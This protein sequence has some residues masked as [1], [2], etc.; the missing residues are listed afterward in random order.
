MLRD[1]ENTPCFSENVFSAG[2]NDGQIGKNMSL[3]ERFDSDKAVYTSMKDLVE[4]IDGDFFESKDKIAYCLS[5]LRAQEVDLFPE[6]ED[7]FAID[8]ATKEWQMIVGFLR[9]K[10]TAL[11]NGTYRCDGELVPSGKI[12]NRSDDLLFEQKFGSYVRK[13]M[14]GVDIIAGTYPRLLKQL[15]LLVLKGDD[16]V[17]HKGVKVLSKGFEF[18]RDKFLPKLEQAL[19]CFL[20]CRSEAIFAQM[21]EVRKSVDKILSKQKNGRSPEIK[22]YWVENYRDFMVQ[23]QLMYAVYD[24]LERILFKLGVIVEA[25]AITEVEIEFDDYQREARDLMSEMAEVV[26]GY[27]KVLMHPGLRDLS[28]EDVVEIK[29]FLN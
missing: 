10:K 6:I 21:V 29:S 17:D 14:P 20:S 13:F 1:T 8:F 27:M 3:M 12:L 5:V 9:D 15:E 18:M 4:L 16:V 19:Q 24:K 23:I 7:F 28:E 22:D 26:S 25:G 2:F 11:L